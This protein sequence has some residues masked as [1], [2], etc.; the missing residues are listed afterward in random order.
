MHPCIVMAKDG[1]G[2]R[3]STSL[4][5]LPAVRCVAYRCS[6]G[7]TGVHFT[8]SRAT[9]AGLTSSGCRFAMIETARY[10]VQEMTALVGFDRRFEVRLVDGEFVVTALS[11]EDGP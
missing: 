7:S 1:L 3:R 9:C 10:L 5:K 4:R 11:A 6:L 8:R 2:D